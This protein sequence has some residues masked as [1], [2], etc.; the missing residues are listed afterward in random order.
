MSKNKKTYPIEATF[1]SMLIMLTP[2][3][4]LFTTRPCIHTTQTTTEEIY[5]RKSNK[6]ESNLIAVQQVFKKHHEV[7]E[8]VTELC[9]NLHVVLAHMLVLRLGWQVQEVEFTSQMSEW[10]ERECR[11]VGRSM[12]TFIRTFQQG[13]TAIEAWTLNYPRLNALFD[14]VEGT[15]ATHFVCT[16]EKKIASRSNPR[17]SPSA[18]QTVQGW[19]RL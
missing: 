11:R 1:S 5:A 3:H 14:E 4:L 16:Q 13:E 15:K 7:L 8:K 18:P 12:A 6:V 9:P 2:T 17:M 10:S 19:T